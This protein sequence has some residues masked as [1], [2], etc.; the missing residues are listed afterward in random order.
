[1]GENILKREKTCHII[2]HGDVSFYD[3]NIDLQDGDIC[4]AVDAGFYYCEPF[5]VDPD[6]IIGDMDSLKE[7]GDWS[8]IEEIMEENPE[9]VEILSTEKDDTDTLAAIKAGFAR[10]YRRF[11][12]FG[13][14]GK[15]LDHTFANIQCLSYILNHGGKGY[16]I[17][18]KME[19][20]AIKNDT[21]RYAADSQGSLSV[22]SLGERAEGVY[23]KVMKYLLEDAV[24]TNDFP[25]G[26]SNEFI[27]EEAEIT[28]RNG[29][30]LLIN[31]MCGDWW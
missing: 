2:C 1:M 3:L 8:D 21:I 29:M 18:G 16:I 28:V 5:G 24:V 14:L 19:I 26:I 17:D 12:L 15:R 9:I 10:G 7:K 11:C 20:T 13:A 25:I 30:L 22:F 23:I 27:G 31:D 4:V 6:L